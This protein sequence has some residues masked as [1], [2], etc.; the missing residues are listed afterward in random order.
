M[1]DMIYSV[2][3]AAERMKVSEQHLRYLLARGEVE[4]KKLGRDWVVLSL[5]YQRKRRPKTKRL[6]VEVGGDRWTEGSL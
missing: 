2:K 1:G 6:G 4:G 5:D 3:E